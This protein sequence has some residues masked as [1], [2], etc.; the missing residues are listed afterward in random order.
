MIP[1][2]YFQLRGTDFEVPDFA[3]RYC[4]DAVAARREAE[5]L[6]TELSMLSGGAGR[7]GATLEVDDTDLRPLLVLPLDEARTPR[8]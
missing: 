7:D 1:T 6:A 8:C 2:Y 5:S 4:A 3:G